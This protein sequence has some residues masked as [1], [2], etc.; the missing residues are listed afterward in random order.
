MFNLN[1]MGQSALGWIPDPWRTLLIIIVVTGIAIFAALKTF[2]FVPPECR[3]IRKFCNRPMLRYA[4]QD[5]D[6]RL[7]TKEE[8]RQQ[9]AT[10][11]QCIKEFKPAMYG[12]PRYIKPGFTVVVLLLQTITEINVQMNTVSL[13]PQRHAVPQK[14]TAYDVPSAKIVVQ[15]FDPYKWFLVSKDAEEQVKA[16][17]DTVLSNF[18]AEKLVDD[19]RNVDIAEMQQHFAEQTKPAYDALGIELLQLLPGAIVPNIDA[20]QAQSRREV[21]EA[22]ESRSNVPLNFKG[23][24]A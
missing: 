6:G 11:K 7:Y 21:A 8:I 9:K 4:K 5:A 14:F 16:V 1:E 2:T 18:L 17:S 3:G 20:W 15:V 22:L 10:D 13:S 23:V 24:V 19:V 12:R